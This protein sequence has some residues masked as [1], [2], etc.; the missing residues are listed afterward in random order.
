MLIVDISEVPDGGPVTE[1][2]EGNWNGLYENGDSET[3]FQFDMYTHSMVP[4]ADGRITYLSM[5]GGEMLD[6]APACPVVPGD[7][8]QPAKMSGK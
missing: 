3:F 1:L 8:F 7:A 2:V 4:T 5:E 6:P